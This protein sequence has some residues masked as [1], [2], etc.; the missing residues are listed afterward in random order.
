MER[1]GNEKNFQVS[2]YVICQ[3]EVSNGKNINYGTWNNE[4][5]RSVRNINRYIT[6]AE[7]ENKN[8]G[9]C[10]IFFLCDT[11]CKTAPQWCSHKKVC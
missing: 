4:V 5:R 2:L 1:T 10:Y 11:N 7:E 8:Y 6:G 9:T 3:K